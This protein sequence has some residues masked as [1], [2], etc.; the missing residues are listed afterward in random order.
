MKTLGNL[1][2]FFIIASILLPDKMYA[3]NNNYVLG[4][5]YDYNGIPVLKIN[6]NADGRW[7]V[8]RKVESD[9][10]LSYLR[11]FYSATDIFAIKIN[12]TVFYTYDT[13]N[14]YSQNGGG[15]RL[16]SEDVSATIGT[17]LQVEQVTKKYSS[18]Y[19]SHP[20]YVLLKIQYDKND[21]EDIK[22]TAEIHVE[23][24]SSS[25]NISLAYGFD[26]YVNSYDYSS[27]ATIPDLIKGGVYLNGSNRSGEQT[28]TTAEVRDLTVVGCVNNRAEGTSMGFYTIGGRPFDR[29][30]SAYYYPHTSASSYVNYTN[31]PGLFNYRTTIDNGVAVAYDNLHGGSMYTISTGL[32]F[33]PG[34]VTFPN[35]YAELDY[36]FVN[37][38]YP[39]SP[40]KQINVAMNEPASLRLAISNYG[41]ATINNIG[42]R[43]TMPTTPLPGLTISGTPS[44][45]NLSTGTYNN[46]TTYYQMGGGSIPPQEAGVILA[47]I[48]TNNYGQWTI[49]SSS[50]GYLSSIA[51]LDGTTPAILTVAT[52]VN[53]LSTDPVSVAAGDS[54]TFTVKLPDGINAYRN[55]VVNLKYTGTLPA[56]SARPATMTIPQGSNSGTFTVTAASS[57]VV[58]DAITITLAYT[59]DGAVF[60]GA[61]KVVI[62]TIEPKIHY[63][64][65]NPHLRS[66]IVKQ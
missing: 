12:N 55:I 57:A 36:T 48:P 22:I 66:M 38:A 25:A 54:K 47:S 5:E 64:P 50:F 33:S 21:P 6:V 29:A 16:E 37:N 40:G 53:Y 60:I 34:H 31:N 43:I 15:V 19:D 11:Q 27:A 30:Y 65:V 4:G 61:N 18:S 13:Y 9:E 2:L 63:I 35:T 10:G 59:D 26:S 1:F 44:R 41:L 45:T 7:W 42:F 51:A 24:I 56:F 52:E 46:Y 58:D 39:S 8:Y 23:Q 3:A 17:S 28:F 14:T 62:L 32:I 20:F 49:S